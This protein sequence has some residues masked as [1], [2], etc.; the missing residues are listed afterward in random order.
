M[1]I[2]E[3]VYRGSQDDSISNSQGCL[4]KCPFTLVILISDLM[5]E[6]IIAFTDFCAV[7]LESDV[8][9]LSNDA[10]KAAANWHLKLSACSSTNDKKRPSPKH[11]KTLRKTGTLNSKPSQD[12]NGDG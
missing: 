3:I 11:G 5:E 12:N 8:G 7:K 6:R 1:D 2:K 10:R 9:L 4:L